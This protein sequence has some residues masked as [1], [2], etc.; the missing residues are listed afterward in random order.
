MM[1][2]LIEE[3]ANKNHEKG[4]EICKL[5]VVAGLT[6]YHFLLKIPSSTNHLL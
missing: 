1:R 2:N 3:R 5:L 4:K 6:D